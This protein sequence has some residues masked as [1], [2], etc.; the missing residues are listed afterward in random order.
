MMNYFSFLDLS[1]QVG[2]NK[3]EK[4]DNKKMDKIDGKDENNGKE[5]STV[6]RLRATV[7]WHLSARAARPNAE[8]INNA[9]ER[10]GDRQEMT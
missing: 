7:L 8:S 2:K 5:E 3:W 10:C 6:R 1:G 4:Y 9:K